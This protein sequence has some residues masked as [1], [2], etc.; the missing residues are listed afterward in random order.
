M[1]VDTGQ[2]LRTVVCLPNPSAMQGARWTQG[3]ASTGIIAFAAMGRS[4]SVPPE[5]KRHAGNEVEIFILDDMLHH[6]SDPC[7]A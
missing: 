6:S 4:Y 5:S 7:L 2:C 1:R 3:S